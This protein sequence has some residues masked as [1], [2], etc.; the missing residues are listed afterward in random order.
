MVVTTINSMRDVRQEP[1]PSGAT[2][3]SKGGKDLGAISVC[4]PEIE[5]PVSATL[6]PP[7]SNL[8]LTQRSWSGVARIRKIGEKHKVRPRGLVH[9]KGIVASEAKRSTAALPYLAQIMFTTPLGGVPTLPK[10]VSD[11]GASLQHCST[12]KEHGDL[13][14]EIWEVWEC[15]CKELLCYL[16][17]LHGVGA[18]L[19]TEV[20]QCCCN[21]Y[22]DEDMPALQHQEKVFSPL[23][24]ACWRQ[25]CSFLSLLLWP[26]C[27]PSRG[28]FDL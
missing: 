4:S 24:T 13:R 25:L 21:F 28:T 18:A 8:C 5:D 23:Q 20:I 6:K 7:R 22:P 9:K 1:W 2:P 26:Q 17:I 3:I 10:V 16:Q 19:V 11:K 27:F 12:N 14:F 15:P